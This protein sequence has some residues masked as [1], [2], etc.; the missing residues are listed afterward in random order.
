MTLWIPYKSEDFPPARNVGSGT[1]KTSWGDL[2][3]AALTVGRPSIAA[4]FQH[5]IPSLFEAIFRIAL[6]GIAVE[7]NHCLELKRT[8]AFAAL[9][10]SEKRMVNYSLGMV[11]CKLFA[12]K[13]LE[14]PW[15][16][17][18]DVYCDVL[19]VQLLGRSRPDLIGKDNDGGWHAFECK[20]RSFTP[21]LKDKQ[22]AKDQAKC[23][24][25]V[26]GNP[27][28]LHIGSFAYFSRDVLHFYWRDPE[29][30]ELEPI[31]VPSPNERWRYYYEPAF[32]LAS[33]VEIL[34]LLLEDSSAHVSI[35]INP[36]IYEL[37]LGGHWAKA[38]E[39]AIELHQ[40]FE[41]RG[42]QPDGIRVTA[43]E[44]WKHPRKSVQEE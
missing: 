6:I 20:G 2:I 9:D 8:K 5:G 43:G 34:P 4:V 21:S 14:A 15:L 27:C 3:W 29:P 28:K 1:L 35:E 25:N 13:L 32:R 31:E 44:W 7:P 37:L 22:K 24:V 19:N 17:H 41:H 38:H 11:V 26:G 30:S 12:S 39:T 10:P 42:F 33:Q 40:E 18:L 36:S 23:S 16:L